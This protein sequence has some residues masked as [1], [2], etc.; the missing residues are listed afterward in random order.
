MSQFIVSARKYRPLRFDDVVGQEHVSQ[1]LKNAIRQN[2]LAHAFLFCGP[3]GV[4]KTSCARI[5]AKVLN[6]QNVT[7]DTEPCN[8]CA[9][10]LAFDRSASLNIIELDAAS[11]NSVEHIRILN[12]QVRFQPQEGRYKVFIIDEV[13][14]LSSSAF[15]A[16][17]KTLEEPPPYAIFI[18]ATTEKHKII[19]T[20]LS[21]CQIFD[22]KRIKVDDIVRQ[23]KYV[24]S[25]QEI[26]TDDEALHL[27]ATKSDGALRDALSILD[28]LASFG[29]KKI[30]YQD[31]ITHLNILDYDYFFKVTN[32]MAMGDVA[33]VLR[34]FDE[35]QQK[36]FEA[37]A[38]LSG[39]AEHF[40]NLL[41]CHHQ[42][43]HHLL[44]L[45]EQVKTLY[46]NQAKVMAESFI[47]SALEI[48]NDCDVNYRM[49]KNKR[50]HVELALIKMNF[51]NQKR[52]ND[53]GFSSEKKSEVLMRSQPMERPA[54]SGETELVSGSAEH[55]VKVQPKYMVDGKSDAA[56]KNQVAT[57][58]ADQAD[59]RSDQ[60]YPSDTPT[61]EGLPFNLRKKVGLA[62]PGLSSLNHLVRAVEKKY[63][64][65]KE[66]DSL[67]I[68]LD[69]V[70]A[71]WNEYA[72]NQT[73]QTVKAV[74]KK[75]QLDVINNSIV[76]T[77]GSMVS[78][79]VILQE[80]PLIE[81][82]RTKLGVPRLT[83]SIEI[84]GRYIENEERPKLL[85]TKEKFEHLCN[86]NPQLVS[87]V[88][89]FGMKPDS[90]I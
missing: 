65:R 54:T 31:V 70:E 52:T 19:P 59:A 25:S 53:A 69:Q 15:N 16:F 14:M 63:E 60:E 81:D 20:I 10:C 62:G 12:E 64:E 68:S 36:G 6:C 40:R 58:P 77:V 34:V 23:L 56:I 1:T 55:P 74:L 9:S 41:V 7:E 8:A 42:S 33:G 46:L 75:T 43:I 30:S 66:L 13:H 48:A 87:F 79:S 26:E 67:V 5:L 57:P 49:A 11:H 39:L 80:V 45:S 37:D 83:I 24:C 21:R 51:I 76:A 88:G 27:I 85:T 72:E 17:L 84:D 61:G 22:F 3:R 90:D 29:G 4:G 2:T 38:F 71:I 89:R 73:S 78:K 47:L 32:A 18:L 35:I 28:K 86:Q 44:E 50:L 82:L